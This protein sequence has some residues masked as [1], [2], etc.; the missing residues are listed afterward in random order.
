[1]LSQYVN[2][3]TILVGHSLEFDLRGLR[4]CHYNIIDTAILFSDQQ[5][6]SLGSPR[7]PA[8]R[9]LTADLLNRHIQD[10][11]NGHCS[12]ED[13]KACLDLLSK[14]YEILFKIKENT[15]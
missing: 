8:L 2:E 4:L 5:T 14:R 3:N 13:A 1:M 6:E 7:K 12:T 9:T 10:S 11:Q 15:S